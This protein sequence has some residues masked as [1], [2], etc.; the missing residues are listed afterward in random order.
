MLRPAREKKGETKLS[1]SAGPAVGKG[2]PLKQTAQGHRGS[3]P[4]H[5][6]SSSLTVYLAELINGHGM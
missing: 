6:K 2:W 1:R 3:E 4:G 5:S